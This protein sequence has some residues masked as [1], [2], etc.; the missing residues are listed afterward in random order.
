MLFIT[1]LIILFYLAQNY[2]SNLIDVRKLELKRQVELSL[3]TVEPILQLVREGELSREE[4][5]DKTKEIIRRM[6]YTGETMD[7][8]IFMSTYEGVMLAQPLEPSKQD[9]LQLDM[10]DLYGM[11]MEYPLRYSLLCTRLNHLNFST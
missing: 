2:R 1:M 4:G 11:F 3:N 10:Q 5:I 9:T 6:T 7:N 8:Y